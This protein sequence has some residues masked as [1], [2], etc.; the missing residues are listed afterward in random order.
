MS[1]ISATDPNQLVPVLPSENARTARGADA[2]GSKLTMFAE[3]DEEASFWDILDVINPLQHIPV[4]NT[5]YQEMTGDKIGVGAR[6]AGGTL[7]GGPI[8]LIASAVGVA[9]EDAT[10]DDLGG[11]VLALFRD[12][13][14][15]DAPVQVAMAKPAELR[16]TTAAALTPVVPAEEPPPA[17][18]A[19][20]APVSIIPQEDAP[21][22]ATSASATPTLMFTV[23]GPMDAVQPAGAAIVPPTMPLAQAPAQAQPARFMPVPPRGAVNAVT[24]PPP[25][26]VPVSNSGIRSN[27]P[28]TGR[29]P[30]AHNGPSPLA[31]QKIMAEQGLGNVAHP[32]LPPTATAQPVTKADGAPSPKPAGGQSDWLSAMNQALDKYERSGNL[33]A[34]VQDQPPV[35]LQ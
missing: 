3:G 21:T 8:G 27:V 4:V 11:H 12:E 19:P 16:D 14:P 6:L 15:A 35:A 22:A 32:M 13:A 20:Q 28:I 33:A 18:A 24:A 31:V 26:S 7:F 2:E 17:I 10:G 1:A 29:D 25:V 30:V 9:V 5:L 34:R 23:D